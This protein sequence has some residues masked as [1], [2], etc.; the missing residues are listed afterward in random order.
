MR[1][2]DSGGLTAAERVRREKVRLEAADMIEAR[3]SDAEVAGR[4]ENWSPR[5]TG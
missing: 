1:Y 3:A 5:G 2:P 4:Y